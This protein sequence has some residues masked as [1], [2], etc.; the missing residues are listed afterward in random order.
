VP[1]ARAMVARLKRRR[2]VIIDSATG[3]GTYVVV[4]PAEARVFQPLGPDR[5][6]HS[7]T[8]PTGHSVRSRP[9][10]YFSRNLNF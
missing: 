5:S 8:G 10:H 7:Q 1:V 4:A 2:L 6:V 9:C 3:G